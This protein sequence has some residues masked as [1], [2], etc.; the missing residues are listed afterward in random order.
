MAAE[1]I[2]SRIPGKTTPEV[3]SWGAVVAIVFA[4][5]I[6][7]TFLFAGLGMMNIT[8]EMVQMSTGMFGYIVGR[9]A[10]V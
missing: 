6:V 10:T 4:L 8:P 1:E 3:K 5:V 9:A 7:L 2:D